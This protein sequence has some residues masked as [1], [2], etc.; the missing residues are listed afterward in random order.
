M[1]HSSL[2]K[3]I[4]CQ[5]IT[6]CAHIYCRNCI[7]QH[8]DAA[9]PPATC[10]LCRRPIKASLLLEAAV[11]EE[12]GADAN[13]DAFDDIVIENSSTKI[14]AVLKELVSRYYRNQNLS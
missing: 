1:S 6:P 14:N 5:V 12:N 9:T 10:P 3:L 13:S 4:C 2:M 11:D 8:I 7:T